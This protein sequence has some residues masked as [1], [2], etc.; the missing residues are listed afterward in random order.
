MCAAWM[1]VSSLVFALMR[2]PLDSRER[3]R[4]VS[5][6]TTLIIQL[7]GRHTV[8]SNDFNSRSCQDSCPESALTATCVNGWQCLPRFVSLIQVYKSSRVLLIQSLL[9]RSR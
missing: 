8:A 5:L 2:P 7:S 9:S 6:S 1:A 3:V 4:G